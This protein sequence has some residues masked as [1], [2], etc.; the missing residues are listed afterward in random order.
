MERVRKEYSQ[1]DKELIQEYLEA[2]RIFNL[3]LEVIAQGPEEKVQL[4][5]TYSLSR[6]RLLPYLLDQTPQLVFI[7]SPEFVR[8]LLIRVSCQRGN[9]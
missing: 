2:K 1:K 6:Y 8:R 7:S 4:P 5:G 9:L 3:K